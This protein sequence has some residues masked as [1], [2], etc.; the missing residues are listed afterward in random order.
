[1]HLCS[2]WVNFDLW[3][4][5][6]ISRNVQHLQMFGFGG[7]PQSPFGGGQEN[8]EVLSANLDKLMIKPD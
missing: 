7:V 3:R 2:D 4:V 1:M 8:G 6:A 5:V